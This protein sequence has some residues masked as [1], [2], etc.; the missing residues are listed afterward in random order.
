MD[1][2]TIIIIVALV[3]LIILLTLYGLYY[4]SVRIRPFPET[5]ADCPKNWGS[6]LS[7][8]CINPSQGQLNRLNTV[9]NTTPGYLINGIGFN[10]N[11][12]KWDSYLGSKNKICGKKKWADANS[13]SWDGISN[14]NS[15]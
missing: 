8:N 9:P 3:F 5:Q 13:L 11:D 4:N 2:Y 6:D 14:Y 10:P 1:F 15:C 7:G 12:S